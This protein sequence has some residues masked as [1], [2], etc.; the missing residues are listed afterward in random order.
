MGRKINYVPFFLAGAQIDP[1]FYT[2]IENYD[3]PAA[4]IDIEDDEDKRD[5]AYQVQV[6]FME[7]FVEGRYDD[8]DPYGSYDDLIVEISQYQDDERMMLAM[9]TMSAAIGARL[10][11]SQLTAVQQQNYSCNSDKVELQKQI[12]ELETELKIARGQM[13]D[14]KQMETKIEAKVEIQSVEILP[15]IAQVNIVMGW[16]YYFYG[17]EP[18]KPIEPLKYLEAKN[19][20]MQYG[21]MVSEETGRSGA[22]DELMR[23]L[24]QGKEERLAQIAAEKAA[25]QQS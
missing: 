20:V 16:Y 18:Y 13:E 19:V 4:L 7:P 5:L 15:M 11:N 6:E 3:I 12:D 23:R 8:I 22:Y 14:F 9:H 1:Y 21:Y 24:I 2:A 17:F 10:L 25:Q